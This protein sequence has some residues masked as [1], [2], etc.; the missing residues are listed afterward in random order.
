MPTVYLL[1]SRQVGCPAHLNFL[2]ECED[3]KIQ[4]VSTAKLRKETRPDASG[5]V[6]KRT[7]RVMRTLLSEGHNVVFHDI[8][9]IHKKYRQEV[10]HELRLCKKL[11][12]HGIIIQKSDEVRFLEE[13]L[14][15][16]WWW[17]TKGT[18]MTGGSV[19]IQA[20]SASAS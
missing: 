12:T 19:G 15:A 1:I 8:K 16:V 13:E 17:N 7:C 10:L 14:D 20:Y 4:L 6:F 9:L 18:M 5:T 11:T 2:K 3:R